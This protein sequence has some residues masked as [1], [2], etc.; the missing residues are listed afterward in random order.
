MR[1]NAESRSLRFL[2]ITLAAAALALVG[3]P[4]QP[5][6]A[7]KRPAAPMRQAAQPQIWCTDCVISGAARVDWNG[8]SGSFYVERVENR[9]KTGSGPLALQVQLQW[10][11]PQPEEL[12]AGVFGFSDLVPLNPLPPGGSQWNINSGTIG[13]HGS[14]VPA[15][16]YW[17]LLLLVNPDMGGWGLL[18]YVVTGDKASCD[19]S[20]CAVMHRSPVVNQLLP[21]VVDVSGGSLHYATEMALTNNT[22]DPLTISISYA[23]SL[24]SKEGSGAV[25]D[26]LAPGEQ[27]QIGDVLSYLRDMGLSIPPSA[28]QPSQGGTLLVSFQGNEPIDPRLVSVT[29]RTAAVTA[30][31]HPVGQAGLAYSGLLEKDFSTSSLTLFGL[32]STATDRTNVAVFN[33]SGYPVTLKVTVHSGSGNG[34]FVVFRE[35]ETLPPYGWLQYG[36]NQILGDSGIWN[37]WVTFERTSSTGSFSA[38]AVINDSR[39]NDGSFVPPVGGAAADSTLIV[40]V[41]TETPDF[42]SELTLANKS[43][44]NVTLTLTYVESQ[45]SSSGPGGTITVQLGPRQQQIVPEAID[46]LRANGANIGARDA[47]S[48]VGALRITVSGTSAENVFAGARTASQ[49][50]A[51]GQFGLFTPCIYSGWGG[52]GEVYLYGLRADP[53]SRSNVAAVYTGEDTWGPIELQFQAYDGDNGGIPKGNPV[54]VSL[55][56]GQWVQLNNF[57]K[58]AGVANGWVKIR[59]TTGGFGG[60]SPWV[61]YAVINDGSNPGE[62]TGDGAYVP[63]VK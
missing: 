26:S 54:S 13:F 1:Q 27:K 22:S 60:G 30:A 61:A 62:R 10:S 33:T 55:F 20:S 39:T 34:R 47:A 12:C 48:Y 43:D 25:T 36:S 51:G 52:P 14:D 9:S 42:R 5:A 18:N 11:Y 50:P 17:V 21:V 49:S 35:A 37:G 7:A 46:F 38:Y 63:M 28:Q 45:T 56:P 40:P 31:P 29:A 58:D 32:R 19:G 24:G 23:A 4:G 16:E 59:E 3:V 8:E 44:S 53:E 41:L 15:G 57:F 6:F 2:H